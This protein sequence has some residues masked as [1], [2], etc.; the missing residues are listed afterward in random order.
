MRKQDNFNI[1]GE[2]IKKEKA[3]IFILPIPFDLTCSYKEGTAFAPKL[4]NKASQQVEIYLDY[5]EGDMAKFFIDKGEGLEDIYAY[6]LEENK[7]LRREINNLT[8]NNEDEEYTQE[9][10][11][12]ITLFQERIFAL[13]EAWYNEFL[14]YT[15]I[16]FYKK[17]P[18]LL[19]G[20]H[21]VTYGILNTLNI[22]NK[23]IEQ[24]FSVLHF[25][26]HADLRVSYE[27]LKY[28][29][30][31]VMYEA[32]K[33]SNIEKIIQVG[34]RDLDITEDVNKTINPKIIQ[35]KNSDI[36][37]N[38]KINWDDIVFS[39]ISELTKL[40]NKNLYI[41]FDV[42]CLKPY[43][44]PNTGT[45]VPGGF[46]YEEIIYFFKMLNYYLI[47]QEGLNIIGFDIVETGKGD[48]DANVS[49]RLLYTIGNLLIKKYIR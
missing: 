45:P 23:N 40:D 46:E 7:R 3:D 26:A 43:L 49:A 18:C 34:I 13:I 33:L 8:F 31:S 28:S 44:C 36:N 14:N 11:D 20:D 21:S 1:F 47:Q 17:I 25:D 38:P 42:D 29:H 12:K 16:S 30:A 35:F 37:K 4:I 39:I 9:I 10:I 41:S 19:G 32:S 27:G 22:Y 24:K 15:S 6:I 2:S 48:F 5:I